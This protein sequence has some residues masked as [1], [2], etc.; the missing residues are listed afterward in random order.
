MLV[1]DVEVFWCGWKGWPC[2][3]SCFT[4]NSCAKSSWTLLFV[5]VLRH[6]PVFLPKIVVCL[7]TACEKVN[8]K[9]QM[10]DLSENEK[11]CWRKITSWCK[12]SI[13]KVFWEEPKLLISYTQTA[14][15]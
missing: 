14:G 10:Y 13:S 9:T 1:T 7:T 12:L 5:V 6:C 15:Y 4:G 8:L 2:S 11:I 3:S